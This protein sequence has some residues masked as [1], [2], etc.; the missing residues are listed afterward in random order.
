MAKKKPT[1]EE[2]VAQLEAIAERIEQGEIG[3]EE[4]ITQYEQ[5]MTL[6]KQCRDILSKAEHKIQQLQQRADGSLEA[7]SFKPPKD[8]E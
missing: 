7:R 5:G 3:L 6:V 4:S 8:T 2:A 1:F